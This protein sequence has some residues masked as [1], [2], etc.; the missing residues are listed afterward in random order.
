MPGCK[1]V[2]LALC[3]KIIELHGGKIWAESNGNREVTFKFEIPKSEEEKAKWRELH[4][5]DKKGK[6]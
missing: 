3:K 1:G 2:G 6:K 5:D 4:K